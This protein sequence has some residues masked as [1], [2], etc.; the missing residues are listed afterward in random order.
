MN[1]TDINLFPERKT[2]SFVGIQKNKKAIAMW[3]D[4]SY[5]VGKQVLWLAHGRGVQCI[6]GG[7]REYFLEKV[8]FKARPQIIAVVS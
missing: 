1:K 6:F 5:D 2:Y 8:M 7:I 4:E 3:R